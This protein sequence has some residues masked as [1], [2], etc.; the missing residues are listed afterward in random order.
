MA[1]DQD[2]ALIRVRDQLQTPNKFRIP[3]ESTAT[4]VVDYALNEELSHGT[5]HVLSAMNGVVE[6]YL[7]PGS[8]YW[9]I[10]KSYFEVRTIILNIELSKYPLNTPF[11]IVNIHFR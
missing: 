3:G 4:T 11:G 6:G 8:A 10:A 7:S 9:M 2:W 1:Y 5:I